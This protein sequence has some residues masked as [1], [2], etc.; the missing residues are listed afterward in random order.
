MGRLHPVPVR[1]VMSLMSFAGL[2]RK[3]DQLKDMQNPRGPPVKNTLHKIKAQILTYI[4]SK[5]RQEV[6]PI[7]VPVHTKLVK[8]GNSGCMAI[9]V[10]SPLISWYF[11]NQQLK[12]PSCTCM[13]T[14]RIRGHLQAKAANPDSLGH[15]MM[16]MVYSNPRGRSHSR[17][18]LNLQHPCEGAE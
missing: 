6:D 8:K 10:T 15:R 2:Y 13:I 18:R 16:A 3:Y 4:E 14:S 5:N 9:I 12:R 17:I 11:L 7:L 1:A